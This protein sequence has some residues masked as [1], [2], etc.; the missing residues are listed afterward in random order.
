[1]MLSTEVLVT[2]VITAWRTGQAYSSDPSFRNRSRAAKSVVGGLIM[3]TFLLFEL[4]GI[5]QLT[6]PHVE[7][8]VSELSSC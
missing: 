6:T 4:R 3:S 7:T 5:E 2:E 8:I 1:M